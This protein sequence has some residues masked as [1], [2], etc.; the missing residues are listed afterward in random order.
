[1]ENRIKGLKTLIVLLYCL[2]IYLL[3]RQKVSFEFIL[4]FI[5]IHLLLEGARIA[6]NKEKTK[7]KTKK[8]IFPKIHKN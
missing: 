4:C 6:L 1:M 5:F 7:E 2:I 3:I 8:I